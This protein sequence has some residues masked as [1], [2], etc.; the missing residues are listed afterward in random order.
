MFEITIK[1]PLFFENIIFYFIIVFWMLI[2]IISLPLL[3]C[4]HSK[5]HNMRTWWELRMGEGLPRNF[6]R[7]YENY[8][9]HYSDNA[10]AAVFLKLELLCTEIG[11]HIHSF[12]GCAEITHNTSSLIYNSCIDCKHLNVPGWCNCGFVN[13]EPNTVNAC[14]IC[15]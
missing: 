9:I 1:V 8:S 7:F 15:V 14:Q 12:A 3:C 2:L 5:T 10:I 11:V 6:L 13:R 4:V